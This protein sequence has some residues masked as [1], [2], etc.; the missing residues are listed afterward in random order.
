MSSWLEDFR[1]AYARH[2]LCAVGML[3]MITLAGL[4][5]SIAF[6]VHYSSYGYVQPSTAV[7]QP[8]QGQ[9][10]EPAPT[11]GS[12]PPKTTPAGTPVHY[13]YVTVPARTVD[14]AVSLAATVPA[15]VPASPA[16][17]SAA[18]AT[19]AR[20]DPAATA[21]SAT[22]TP[23]QTSTPSAAPTV[24]PSVTQTASSSP[25]TSNSSTP[26]TEAS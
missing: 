6:A 17:P 15:S 24:T 26:S 25:S 3:A 14:P 12:A 9:T 23:T 1:D 2:P 4:F 16:T 7:I 10:S 8:A 13:A 5:A 19:S 21:P 11:S 20:P 22:P 18:Q